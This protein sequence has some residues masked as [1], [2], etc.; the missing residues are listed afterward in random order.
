MVENVQ[1]QD[2][3]IT[4]EDEDFLATA[5]EA[6]DKQFG[7]YDRQARERVDEMVGFK[8]DVRRETLTIL[9]KFKQFKELF[10]NFEREQQGKLP[11]LPVFKKGV[12]FYQ[13]LL[14]FSFDNIL[15]ELEKDIAIAREHKKGYE[16]LK[17][18]KVRDLLSVFQIEHVPKFELGV[19]IEDNIK[20]MRDLPEFGYTGSGVNF[21]FPT[22]A[23]L[24]AMPKDKP[25]QAVKL[26]WKPSSNNYYHVGALQVIY[27]NGVASPVF[28]A[29]EQDANGL[30]TVV[31][32]EQV[33]KIRGTHNNC[34]I[35]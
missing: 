12:S 8:E 15:Q 7:K 2:R 17:E 34:F 33:K 32:N 23:D 9:H 22:D 21:R 25:I 20:T 28:L 27:S 35:R 10:L 29:K 13:A 31:L 3:V 11:E 18:A 1:P 16:Q 6:L 24:R 26:C 4:P 19:S 14:N 5:L 30:Q